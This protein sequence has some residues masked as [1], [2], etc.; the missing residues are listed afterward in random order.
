MSATEVLNL[1]RATGKNKSF[2]VEQIGKALT[3]FGYKKRTKQR[4]YELVI[5]SKLRVAS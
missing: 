4:K 1:I 5:K 3:V 2:S